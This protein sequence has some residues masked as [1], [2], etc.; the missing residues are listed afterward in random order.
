MANLKHPLYQK[1][2]EDLIYKIESK[3]LR[4][5]DKL[6]SEHAL[7]S[8]YNVSRIT[9]RKALDILES[10]GYVIKKQGI[11]TFVSSFSERKNGIHFLDIR[12][13]IQKMGLHSSTAID[14]FQIIADGKVKKVFENMSLKED[15]YVYELKRTYMANGRKLAYSEIY[16]NFNRFPMIKLSEIKENELV[17]FL[18]RKFDLQPDLIESRNIP[19]QVRKEDLEFLDSNLHEPMVIIENIYRENGA[20]LYINKIRIV[21]DLILYLV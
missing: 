14:K 21:S 3:Q 8:E 12:Q 7:C 11:G 1:M 6:S 10:K 16:L 5:G 9:V 19:T 18:C 15:D 2:L 17:P 13:A 4:G 20:L